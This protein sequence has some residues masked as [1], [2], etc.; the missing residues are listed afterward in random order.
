MMLSLGIL[1]SNSEYTCTNFLWMG[2]DQ[3]GYVIQSQKIWILQKELKH[4]YCPKVVFYG[5]DF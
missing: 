4:L 5:E 3:Y 1:S 2:S